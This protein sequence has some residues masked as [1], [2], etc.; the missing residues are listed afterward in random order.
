[1]LFSLKWSGKISL[2]FL[3]YMQVFLSRVLHGTKRKLSKQAM[4]SPWAKLSPLYFPRHGDAS[5]WPATEKLFSLG[6]L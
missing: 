4:L 1:M 5:L 6:L 3:P 2:T